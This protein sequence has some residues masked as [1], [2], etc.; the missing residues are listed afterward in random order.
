MPVITLTENYA[1]Y[2][3]ASVSGLYLSHPKSKYFALGKITED[4][5]RDYHRRKRMPI[6]EIEKWLAPHLS[7][8]PSSKPAP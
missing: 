3:A 2:P 8:E 6:E 4:Q 5:I 7:Y 1:M